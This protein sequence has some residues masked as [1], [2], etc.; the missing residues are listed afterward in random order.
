M[1][2]ERTLLEQIEHDVLTSQPLA[3]TLRKCVVL[4]G[5]AG[6]IELRDWATCE[7][8]GYDSKSDAPDYRTVDAPILADA[9]TGNAIVKRQM[10]GV[11]SLPDFVQEE[12]SHQF[13]L[14]QGIGALEAMAASADNSEN[15]AV[16]L[17]LPM[18]SEIGSL[19]DQASGNPY[20]QIT[21][22]YW[23]IS[24]VVLHGVVDQ[25][26]T[27]LTE[28]VAEMRAGTPSSAALPTAGVANQAVNVAVHGKRARVTVQSAQASEGSSAN[29]KAD[30]DDGNSPFW[31]TSRRIAALFA[32][33]ASIAGAALTVAQV[34][35]WL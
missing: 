1:A 10:I 27:T 8:R 22:L 25:V 23:S 33:L 6:S 11:S 34:R 30:D 2:K 4:G 15:G 12:I 21:A 29:F 19:M 18:A 14:L 32:G 20:Q 35:G 26:R 28:L 5:K 16:N 31:T 24:G 13:T 9:V 17:S 7:L 3:D